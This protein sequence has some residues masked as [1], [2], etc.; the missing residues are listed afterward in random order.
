MALHLLYMIRSNFL[1]DNYTYI[2]P[3]FY[4]QALFA[5]RLLSA[6]PFTAAID[7][8]RIL[9]LFSPFFSGRPMLVTGRRA[10]VHGGQRVKRIRGA[11]LSR[12]RPKSLKELLPHAVILTDPKILARLKAEAR[13]RKQMAAANG[14]GV[15]NGAEF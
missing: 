4:C 9:T 3:V 1:Y 11:P 2:I 7:E 10:M 6:P 13:R 15:K 5:M 14:N 8:L 12:R